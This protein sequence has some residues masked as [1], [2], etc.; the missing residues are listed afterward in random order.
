[1]CERNIDQ[2]LLARP[3]L[4]SW[5]E[6]QECALTGNQTHLSVQRL[7]LSPL[8]HTNQGNMLIL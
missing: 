1:M 4:G 3:L 8:S 5:P 7:A 2:L 6:T